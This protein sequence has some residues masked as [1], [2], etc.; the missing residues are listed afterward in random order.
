MLDTLDQMVR[1]A[2][3]EVRTTLE[4]LREGL[5]RPGFHAVFSLAA[6]PVGEPGSYA[7]F[8]YRRFMSMI[9]AIPATR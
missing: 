7:W 6:T 8:C 1:K 9:F 2:N 3:G 5:N 4:R